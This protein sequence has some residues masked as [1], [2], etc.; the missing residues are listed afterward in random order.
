[1]MAGTVRA[2][3]VPLGNERIDRRHAHSIAMAAFFRYGK[4]HLGRQWRKAASS[5][6]P[7]EGGD[8]SA[9]NARRPVPLAGAA[10]GRRIAEQGH[11]PVGAEGDWR[12]GRQVGRQADR[13]PRRG[14]EPVRR[15]DQVLEE[16]TQQAIGARKFS[17][18]NFFNKVAETIKGRDLIGYL[19]SRNVLPKYGFP[20]DTVDLMTAHTNDR[21][22]GRLELSRDLTSAIYEYAPG[23]EI[24][25]G[26]RL[27][28]SA[29]VYRR[30]GRELTG[31]RFAVCAHCEG[32][33]VGN[34]ELEKVCPKCE[35]P[36]ANTDIT[37][38]Y[39]IPE[40]GFLAARDT[41]DPGMSP[42]Q[43]LWNGSAYVLDLAAEPE[44]HEW[45]NEGGT[46]VVA[47]AGAR[48]RLLALSQIWPGE[49]VLDLT[50]MRLGNGR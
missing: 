19:A 6:C 16:R 12:L 24:V 3:Y 2:P 36:Y 14:P 35:R 9:S 46:A 47:R 31:K 23:G 40:F 30:P 29:G 11:P 44:E 38:R 13:T 49:R 21:M 37:G 34:D 28:T 15:E 43:R 25:A 7:G 4:V 1:M 17:V 26:G 33:Q 41:R 10:G 42:P 22:G 48:G 20:V 32:I 45:R 50:V 39:V 18:A 27:W 8:R 5:S